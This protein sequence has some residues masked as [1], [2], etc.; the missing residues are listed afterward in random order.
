MAILR[1]ELP[2][3]TAHFDL[4]LAAEEA[5]DEA[6]VVP[7]WR[8][9]VDPMSMAGGSRVEVESLPPH[10]GLYLRLRE[11]RELGDGRGLVRPVHAGWHARRDGLLWLAT[12]EVVER[13]FTLEGRTLRRE[14]FDQVKAS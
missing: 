1:H 11:P 2:D 12:R 3:G 13:P 9:P 8:C 14:S 7:T 10:R 6:R 4:L 5:G